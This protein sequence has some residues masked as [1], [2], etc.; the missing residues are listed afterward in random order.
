M[1][2]Y[3]VVFVTLPYTHNIENLFLQYLPIS[4]T[5]TFNR[6]IIHIIYNLHYI[7]IFIHIY[8][9]H[10]NIILCNI[11]YKYMKNKIRKILRI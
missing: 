2:V 9:H 7:F 10:I 3:C 6:L 8:T 4:Y 5:Q 11:L 1:F